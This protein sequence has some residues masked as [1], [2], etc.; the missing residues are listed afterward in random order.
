MNISTPIALYAFEDGYGIEQNTELTMQAVT[1][2]F[3]LFEDD[4]RRLESTIQDRP[5]QRRSGALIYTQVTI[6]I[7]K[8]QKLPHVSNPDLNVYR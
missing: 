4:V 2:L 5:A 1:T 8:S 7:S 6:G 3:P